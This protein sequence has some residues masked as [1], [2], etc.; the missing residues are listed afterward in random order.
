MNASELRQKNER[1]LAQL[2]ESKRH[3]LWT[4]RFGA[5][6]SK[7]RNVKQGRTIRREIARILTILGTMKKQ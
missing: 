2:L 5:S 4:F 6:G 7:V 3:E 1:E